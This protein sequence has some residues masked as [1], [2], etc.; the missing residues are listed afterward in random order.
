MQPGT[1]S[2]ELEL[3]GI[4]WVIVGG[5]SGPGAHPMDPAWAR[6][7]RDKCIGAVLFQAVGKPCAPR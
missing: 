5:E 1:R 4:N 6:E 2:A 7:L 3:A